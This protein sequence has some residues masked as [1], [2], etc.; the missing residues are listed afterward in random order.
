MNIASFEVLMQLLRD[1]AFFLTEI[2][3]S[4]YYLLGRSISV[5]LFSCVRRDIVSHYYLLKAVVY[6]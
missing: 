6:F 2:E 1:R 5:V 3:H 4:I